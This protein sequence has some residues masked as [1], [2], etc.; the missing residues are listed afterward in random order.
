MD[1]RESLLSCPFTSARTRFARSSSG[2]TRTALAS[3]SCSAWESRSAAAT[4]GSADASAMTRISLGPAIMSIPVRPK[5]SF[6]AVATQALPG[7]TILSTAGTDRVPY[8]IAAT[9]W[10]PPTLK[11]R[12][13]PAICAAA[14]RTG[15]SPPLPTGLA[16]TISLTPAILA[17]MAAMSTV[18]GYAARPPGT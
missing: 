11:I 5:T 3:A 7:P 13:T 2:V 18:E 12:S 16:M 1:A 17:G 6:L 15:L 4:A 9:A 14:A 8:A 10:A